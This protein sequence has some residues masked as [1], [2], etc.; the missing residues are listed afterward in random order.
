[1]AVE[2]ASR[3]GELLTPLHADGLGGGIQDRRVATPL[4]AD[5]LGG[6]VQ[7]RR[8]A[9][10]LQADALGRLSESYKCLRKAQE[11]FTQTER[12]PARLD[13]H[14][15]GVERRVSSRCRVWGSKGLLAKRATH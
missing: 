10:S 8:V 6:G 14:C 3:T 2:M 1:M 11:S 7:D 13:K 9:A 4:H 15:F 5:G 12:T